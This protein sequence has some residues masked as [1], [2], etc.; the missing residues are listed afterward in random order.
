[1]KT[2]EMQ[3]ERLSNKFLSEMTETM[4][5]EAAARDYTERMIAEMKT[6]YT[7]YDAEKLT[8]WFAGLYEPNIV[9]DFNATEEQKKRYSGGAGFY[10]SN[11]ARKKNN[12]L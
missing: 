6:F 1:M 4:G 11:S 5:D 10:Y 3:W 2:Q 12:S 7:I 8:R 9:F